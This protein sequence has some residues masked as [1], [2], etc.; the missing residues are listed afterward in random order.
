[1]LKIATRN[2]INSIAINRI[3]GYTPTLLEIAKIEMLK[4]ALL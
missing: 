4:I 3:S 2:V 1:V